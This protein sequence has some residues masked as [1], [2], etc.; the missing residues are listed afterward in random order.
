MPLEGWVDE[1]EITTSG[2]QSQFSITLIPRAFPPL[3]ETAHNLELF[4]NLID[5]RFARVKL[6]VV[7]ENI[8]FAFNQSV[9][10]YMW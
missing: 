4:E 6:D 10:I 2:S 9:Q 1:T 3:I 7:V 8:D 5:E